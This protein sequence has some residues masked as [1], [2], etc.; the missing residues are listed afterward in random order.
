M[1]YRSR[2][3]IR[4]KAKGKYL[5]AI[6]APRAATFMCCTLQKFAGL[7]LTTRLNN[8]FY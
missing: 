7:E 6:M 3:N 1:A 4:G 5:R 8:Q 2:K